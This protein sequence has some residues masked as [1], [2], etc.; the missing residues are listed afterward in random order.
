MWLQL[1]EVL[2]ME[3]LILKMP[4]KYKVSEGTVKVDMIHF[5]RPLN[6][7]NYIEDD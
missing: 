1:I 2:M 4:R 7:I 3:I 5:Q 6:W